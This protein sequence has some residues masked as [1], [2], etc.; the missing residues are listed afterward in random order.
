MMGFA[1]TEA[2]RPGEALA[3]ERA[4]RRAPTAPGAHFGLARV[5]HAL[6]NQPGTERGLAW[7]RAFD[8][9]LAQRAQRR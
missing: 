8:P 6:G 5:Y 3:F 2:G 1:L 7:L 4:V 9:A